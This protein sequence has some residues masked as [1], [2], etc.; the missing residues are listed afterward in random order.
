MGD[1]AR[2]P[3]LLETGGNDGHLEFAN[4]YMQRLQ[5]LFLDP[6]RKVARV[7]RRLRASLLGENGRATYNKL[8]IGQFGPGLAGGT[9]MSTGFGGPSRAN[10]WDFVLAL[11]GATLF[12]GAAVRRF[13]ARSSGGSFPFHV[14]SSAAGYG[15]ASASEEESARSELWLPLWPEPASLP[16]LLRLFSEGRLELQSRDQ[17]ARRAWTGVEAAR[18]LAGLGVDRG[19]DRFERVGILRRNGLAFFATWLGTVRARRVAEIDLLRDVDEHVSQAR[20]TEA[21]PVRAAVRRINEATLA[22]ARG[23]ASLVAV[24]A[25]LG[26]LERALV[27]SPECREAVRPLMPLPADW[28]DALSEAP[29]VPELVVAAAFA[30]WGLRTALLPVDGHRQRWADRQVVPADG[31]FLFHLTSVALQRLRDAGEGIVPFGG[32]STLTHAALEALLTGSLARD[33][34]R[35]L[36]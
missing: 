24:V 12:A 32:H 18:S 2:F 28:W 22:L 36:V 7:E 1:D 8:P 15:S 10:P 5:E 20:R 3:A 4:N 19:I 13:D 6:K 21:A 30:S 31:D 17:P 35:D 23:N 14:R 29:R 25:G 33:L 26:S 34:F 9:N 16:A 11:E 27:R